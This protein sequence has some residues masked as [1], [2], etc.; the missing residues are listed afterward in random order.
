MRRT[1]EA[2]NKGQ[3]RNA[4]PLEESS[5][6]R[7]LPHSPIVF[8][9]GCLI[10]ALGFAGQ[11]QA[12]E[13]KPSQTSGRDLQDP[14]ATLIAFYHWYVAE[15]AGHRDPLH[16]DRGKMESYVSKV[17]LQEIDRRVN[18]PDGLDAD[19]FTQAQ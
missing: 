14:Q 8:A 10:L 12:R 18:S 5:H 15:L 9:I 3:N 1:E 11:L 13:S 19:Y 7:R 4:E 17:L 2:H 6:K 16:D